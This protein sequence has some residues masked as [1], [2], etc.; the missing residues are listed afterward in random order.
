[1]LLACGLRCSEVADLTLQHLQQREE[2]WVIADL[3]G[4]AAHIRTG[5]GRRLGKAE[6]DEWTAAAEITMGPL[7]GCISRRARSGVKASRRRSSDTS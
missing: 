1:V 4:K 5:A 2:H 7:F 3:I 6:I